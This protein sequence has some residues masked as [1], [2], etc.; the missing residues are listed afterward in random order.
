MSKPALIAVLPLTLAACVTPAASAS[1]PD[2]TLTY[3]HFGQTGTVDGP[4]IAPLSLIEDSRCPA[5]VACAWAGQVRVTVRI[6]TGRGA[7]VREMTSS[8][9]VAVA[10]G[11]LELVDV[12]PVKR[13]EA[14]IPAR[15]YRL[16]F[17][18]RGGL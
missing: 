10:D 12:R 16:G 17:R 13:T 8:R 14:A 11:S 18:F 5:S 7:V 6:M 1:P 9:P 4:R 2:P 15:D 3:L